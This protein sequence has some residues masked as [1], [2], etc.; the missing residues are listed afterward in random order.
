MNAVKALQL[1]QQY[2]KCPDCGNELVGK[3][4]GVLEVTDN[5]FLRKCKCGFKVEVI[6]K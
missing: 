3:N 4:Q 6:E 1:I 2:A 5:K